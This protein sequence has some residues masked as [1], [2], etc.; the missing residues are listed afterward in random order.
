MRTDRESRPRVLSFPAESERHGRAALA[1]IRDTGTS[2]A[3][4]C[5][6]MLSIG[7]RVRPKAQAPSPR[8]E[9]W[10]SKATS[11]HFLVLRVATDVRRATREAS[12][13]VVRARLGQGRL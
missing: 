7:Y 1:P 13:F 8:I 9:N 6:P 12:V 11:F 3:M 2:R 10:Q 4:V 5:L